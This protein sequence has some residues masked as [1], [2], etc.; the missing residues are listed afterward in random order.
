MTHASNAAGWTDGVSGTRLAAAT[1]ATD[2][3]QLAPNSVR[4]LKF[5]TGATM[6]AGWIE[7]GVPCWLLSHNGS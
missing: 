5:L 7:Q 2:V 1:S 6:S 3:A 4:K